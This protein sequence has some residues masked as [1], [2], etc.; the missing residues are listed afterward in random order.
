[1]DKPLASSQPELFTRVDDY[2]IA[3]AAAAAGEGIV[4]TTLVV[5]A[6]IALAM[7]DQLHPGLPMF[8]FGAGLVLVTAL[9]MRLRW[10]QLTALPPLLP[11]CRVAV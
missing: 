6:D 8:W 5:V 4:M 7:V 10:Q 3:N 1:M 2:S 9:I 11:A